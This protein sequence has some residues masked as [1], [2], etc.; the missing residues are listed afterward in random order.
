MA[1]TRPKAPWSELLDEGR[2]D[3]RLVR[4]ARYGAKA[5]ERAALPDELHPALL[6]ALERTGVRTLWAH[7]REAL[8]A[9]WEG[10]TLVPTGTASAESPASNLRVLDPPA[11]APGGIRPGAGLRAAQRDGRGPGRPGRA[12]DGAGLPAGR[13]RRRARGRAPGGDVE[14]S[15]A[16]REDRRA[17]VGAVRGRR[18]PGAPG[19]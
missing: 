4:T 16:G 3:E 5:A 1:K 2:A 13:P 19:R 6:E 8:E 9:A 10:P 15:A 12:A 7:Q 11:R 18:P 17:R 14:P